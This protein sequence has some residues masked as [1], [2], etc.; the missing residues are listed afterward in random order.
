[1]EQQGKL[2]VMLI[3]E[4]IETRIIFKNALSK[5]GRQCSVGDYFC[6]DKAVANPGH[7][8]ADNPDIIFLDTNSKAGDCKN[9]IRQIRNNEKFKDCSLVVYDSN[10]QLRDTQGIFSEGADV[11]INRP[12]DFS[13]LK[14]V[15]GSILSTAWHQQ[16][17]TSINF[18]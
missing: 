15:I 17:A 3:G 11:F 2:N 4:N 14:K 7:S 6:V 12:Y 18:I 5:S 1:M 16:K 10:S 8:Y 9:Q 13:R